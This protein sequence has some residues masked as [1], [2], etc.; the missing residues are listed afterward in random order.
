MQL[1]ESMFTLP[2]IESWHYIPTF[3][4]LHST[5]EKDCIANCIKFMLQ[6]FLCCSILHFTSTALLFNVHYIPQCIPTHC[7]ALPSNIATFCNSFRCIPISNTLFCITFQCSNISP[8]KVEHRE[9]R[10]A[11]REELIHI[12][13]ASARLLH[14]C[15]YC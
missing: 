8:E 11:C 4:I 6:H 3:C 7:F 13:G 5:Q 9:E 1:S 2:Y 10:V 14:I 15:L 12:K